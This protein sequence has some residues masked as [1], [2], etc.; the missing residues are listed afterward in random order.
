VRVVYRV[1]RNLDLSLSHP[2]EGMKEGRNE[3][4]KEG[5]KE[6]IPTHTHTTSGTHGFGLR[7]ESRPPAITDLFEA[8]DDIT[9]DAGALAVAEA[10]RP[11]AALEPALA[12]FA[13]VLLLAH[14]GDEFAGAAQAPRG[15][16]RGLPRHVQRVGEVVERLHEVGR[17]AV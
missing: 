16:R 5:R 7:D 3:G 12:L 9:A 2:S 6:G 11:V 15:R 10:L 1:V 14:L 8:A 4:R 13:G 17:E